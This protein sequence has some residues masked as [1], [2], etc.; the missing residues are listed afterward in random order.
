LGQNKVDYAIGRWYC[1]YRCIDCSDLDPVDPRDDV[2]L[3][4]RSIL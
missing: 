3:R 2:T 1:Q 4:Y